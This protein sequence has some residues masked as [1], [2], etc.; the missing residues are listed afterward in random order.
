MVRKRPSAEILG[1]SNRAGL[2]ADLEI[3]GPH[4]HEARRIANFY[5]TPAT[6]IKPVDHGARL[7]S[8][9][10]LCTSMKRV[11]TVSLF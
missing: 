11:N 6:V 3:L 8:M 4:G 1:L 10:V 5:A 9:Q 2:I 7:F